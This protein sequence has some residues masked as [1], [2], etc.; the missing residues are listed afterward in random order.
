[1]EK[2]PPSQ[3]RTQMKNN[4]KWLS[5]YFKINWFMI[6][7]TW[8]KFRPAISWERIVSWILNRLSENEINALFWG[9]LSV[10]A[11]L[12]TSRGEKLEGSLK[13]IQSINTN[14]F[15]LPL[16]LCTSES[17]FR[18]NCFDC[19]HA[20]TKREICCSFINYSA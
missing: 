9:L 20:W 19:N 15:L 8:G 13:D 6:M 5:S 4:A 1:M 14:Y 18:N 7:C 11:L 10:F 12:S 2:Y 17:T 3:R 16:P